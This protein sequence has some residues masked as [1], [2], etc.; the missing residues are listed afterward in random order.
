MS[1][2]R[3]AVLGGA[4]VLALSAGAAF[5][6]ADA[7]PTDAPKAKAEKRVV[8]VRSENGHTTTYDSA[9]DKGPPP[10]MHGEMAHDGVGHD[11]DRRIIMIHG[12]HRD[13]ERAARH[14]RDMLQLTPAQEPAL[15]AF[16]QSM[17]PPHPAADGDHERRMRFEVAHGPDGKI[18][19]AKTREQAEH[20]R[21]E[22]EGH[23]AEMEKKRAEEAALTTPQRLDR[24]VQHM[25]E[26][27]ARHQSEMRAHV[28]AVKRFYAAL[29]PSQQKAFD[30][31]HHHGMGGGVMMHGGQGMGMHEMHFGE[32]A[33]LPPMPPMPPM[34]PRLAM[35]MPPPPPLPPPPPAPPP[36]PPPPGDR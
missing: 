27:S 14:M 20:F 33:P 1:P 31:M 26:E 13:P 17:H 8:I 34:P 30:A 28:D 16:L 9:V 21:A 29:T 2:F 3:I 32:M 18:D 4:A 23:R 6:A 10:M 12:D 19:P 11:G 15:Q 24:M 35:H 7:A 22:M 5:A 36:P 25:A